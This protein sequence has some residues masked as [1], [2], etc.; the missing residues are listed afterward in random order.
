[1]G[2]ATIFH[3]TSLVSSV[4]QRD[5]IERDRG[6]TQF[7]ERWEADWLML[8][9]LIL[10]VHFAQGLVNWQFVVRMRKLKFSPFVNCSVNITHTWHY[11][12]TLLK[13]VGVIIADCIKCFSSY[14]LIPFLNYLQEQQHISMHCSRTV[15]AYLVIL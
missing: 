14:I 2:S 9:L 3:F 11:L 4:S 13:L 12:T 8:Q 10:S 15:K 1:M 7:D 5:S 6:I